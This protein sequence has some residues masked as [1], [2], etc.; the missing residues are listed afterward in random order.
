VVKGD[1]RVRDVG[2]FDEVE[3][4]GSWTR[5]LHRELEPGGIVGTE[6]GLVTHALDAQGHHGEAGILAGG[7]AGIRL[8]HER[9]GYGGSLS[10]PDSRRWS[11]SAFLY[12]EAR[13][14]ALSL[15]AGL[16]YDWQLA[17]PFREDPDADIGHIR[18]RTFHAVS[19]SFGGLY[20]LPAGVVV[21]ASV[22]RAFRAPDINELYSEGPHLAS[23][24]FE[25]GN[26]ELDTEVGT[27][28]DV[29]VRLD[30]ETVRAEFTAFRNDV[31]GY[32]Y[33]RETGDTSR[34]QLPIYQYTGSDARLEG[35]ETA[36]EWSPHAR[37]VAEANASY[38]RGSFR[39][40]DED[41]PLIPP[42][43]GRLG[44]RYETP[45]WFGGAEVRAARRQDRLGEFETPTEGYAVWGWSAGVRGSLGGH[46]HSV[47]ARVDNVA[48]ETYRNHLS[49]TKEIM[50]EAGRSASVVYRLVF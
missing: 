44:V 45:T 18:D 10:T 19:G 38:V 50:P 6:Y 16:R 48:D 46:L 41:L 42:L 32:L 17:A 9:F 33:P 27:G 22:A 47:T 23:Y 37:W 13:F 34:V 25:V 29:F 39:N 28:L 36:V 14:D 2:V 49:R 43:H 7:T 26:P 35:F 30:R 21:G 24:S 31:D 11:A 4:G 3:V 8:Q 12:E 1:A 20:R 40:R 5:Y 15:E